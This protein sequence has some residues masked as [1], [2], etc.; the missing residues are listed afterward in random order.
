MDLGIKRR[1]KKGK[2]KGN[3]MKVRKTVRKEGF[4]RKRKMK[5][6]LN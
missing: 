5:V 6:N 3:N 4:R 2:C 1:E